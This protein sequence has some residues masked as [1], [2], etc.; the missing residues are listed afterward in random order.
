MRN[1]GLFSF[2]LIKGETPQCIGEGALFN[3]ADLIIKADNVGNAQ[4]IL[5]RCVGRNEFMSSSYFTAIETDR[6]Q[7]SLG[8]PSQTHFECFMISDN[9]GLVNLNSIMKLLGLPTSKFEKELPS[10][11]DVFVRASRKEDAS[12]LIG[13]DFF[14]ELI[15]VGDIPKWEKY[16]QEYSQV[17]NASEKIII[18]PLKKF[19]FSFTREGVVPTEST[20]ELTSIGEEDREAILDKYSDVCIKA[21]N[22]N[23]A[24]M[25][26]DPKSFNVEAVNCDE[27][28]LCKKFDLLN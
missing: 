28:L 19:Y 24:E 12:W 2:V 9:G 18:T 27:R 6:L 21:R 3:E 15:K 1:M 8:A 13:G 16:R 17:V 14:S 5:N 4:N 11:V 25:M 23:E 10:V 20:L 7:R 22:L 26:L